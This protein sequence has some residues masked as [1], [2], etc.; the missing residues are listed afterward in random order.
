MKMKDSIVKRKTA[1]KV[2][3][4]RTTDK[5]PRGINPEGEEIK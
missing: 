5:G 3:E 4:K 1:K 2:N